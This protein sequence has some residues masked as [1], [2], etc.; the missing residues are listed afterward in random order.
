MTKKQQQQQQHQITDRLRDQQ[1]PIYIVIGQNHITSRIC[2]PILHC[3][4]QISCMCCITEYRF[5]LLF[6]LLLPIG[7]FVCRI[8]FVL[9]LVWKFFTRFIGHF[10]WIE[11]NSNTLDLFYFIVLVSRNNYS[12]S[13]IAQI[14]D[15]WPRDEHFRNI[16]IGCTTI[17]Y[18][19]LLIYAIKAIVFFWST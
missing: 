2:K 7:I 18:T 10:E 14:D 6:F 19:L 16:F 8:S 9:V 5:F 4:T 17:A 13:S 1:S 15:H 12:N 3:K 11:I